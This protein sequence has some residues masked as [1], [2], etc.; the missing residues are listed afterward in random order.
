MR[1]LLNE[2]LDRKTAEEFKNSK[3][4][5][6][7]FVLDNIRSMNNIGSAFRTADSFLVE[8]I[9]LCGVSA[10]PPHRE[11]QKTALGATETVSWSYF[12]NTMDCI[13]RLKKNKYTL[14]SVE[15]TENSSLLSNF[16]FSD[17]EKVALVFGNEVFG[18]D[19]EVIN[20]SDWVIEIP[21]SGT[22][23]SLNVSVSIGVVS[24]E[25]YKAMNQK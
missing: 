11:I 14:I 9:C 25:F 12:E 20:N 23:H 18:V 19:Q 10:K 17:F 22:K 21:Q 1:K 15:Q 3:K 8:E 24:W 16:P 7:V 6:L 2:E 4:I 5:P 13:Q